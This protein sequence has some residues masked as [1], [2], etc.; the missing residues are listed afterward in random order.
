MDIATV[1]AN[2]HQ[3]AIMQKVGIAMLDKQLSAEE[4]AGDM[5]A[6]SMRAMPSPSLE[7]MVNPSVGGS[8]DVLV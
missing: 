5:L 6:A 8:I 4:D 3:S 1:S 7:S 2:M